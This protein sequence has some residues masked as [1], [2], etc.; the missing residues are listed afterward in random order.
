MDKENE[1]EAIREFY[2][3]AKRRALAFFT[4]LDETAKKKT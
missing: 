2:L 1:Y 3:K 4:L